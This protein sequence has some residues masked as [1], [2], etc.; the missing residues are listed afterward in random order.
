MG[1]SMEKPG[2]E[3]GVPEVMDTVAEFTQFPFFAANYC[4]LH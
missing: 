4:G 2:G 3:Q 1:E